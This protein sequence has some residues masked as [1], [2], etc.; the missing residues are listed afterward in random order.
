MTLDVMVCPHD[1][2]NNPERW[3]LFVQYLAQHLDKHLQFD[4]SLDFTDFRDNVNKADIVYANPS[5]TLKLLKDGYVAVGHPSNLYDEVV[6]IANLDVAQP[7][8]ES[9]AGQ[10]ILSVAALQPTKLALHILAEKG[11]ASAGITD[12][13]SWTSVIGTIW[14]GEAQYGLIYKDTY[15]ELSEQGK[16]MIQAFYTSDERISFHNILVGKNAAAMSD[17]IA[18]L[19][20]AMHTDEKGNSVL[21]ELHVEQWVPTTPEQIAA[22]KHIMESY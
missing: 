15:S 7:T 20:L 17:D 19:L 10:P 14:R 9:L 8:L 6:F 13:D 1:T 12:C 5:D 2:A 4:I 21:K 11:I 16:E 3:F 18:A 22:I